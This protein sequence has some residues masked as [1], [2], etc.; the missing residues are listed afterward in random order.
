MRTTVNDILH[1]GDA[2]FAPPTSNQDQEPEA[3]QDVIATPEPEENDEHQVKAE[4]DHDGSIAPTASEHDPAIEATTTVEPEQDTVYD[5]VEDQE[6]SEQLEDL[7]DLIQQQIRE[8]SQQVEKP[9][10]AKV[11]QPQ[12]NLNRGQ[13][14]AY[15]SNE[16]IKGLEDYWEE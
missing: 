3:M 1:R 16:E 7:D 9:I 8:E 6:L 14:T 4:P 13:E 2:M 12:R 15:I 5:A 10:S 11:Q